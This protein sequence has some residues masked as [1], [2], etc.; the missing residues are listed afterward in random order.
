[1]TQPLDECLPDVIKFLLGEGE[2]D[3][4][5]FGEFPDNGEQYKRRY[6]WR[7]AL[8]E[9]WNLR[10]PNPASEGDVDKITK[11]IFEVMDVMDGIDI[12]AART[13]AEAALAAM[14]PAGNGEVIK[15]A[16][17]WLAEYGNGNDYML[18]TINLIRDLRNAYMEDMK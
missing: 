10:N 3:G 18:G 6:W 12:T 17:K 4:Y 16:D 2:L 13:Y 14:Q 7:K 1:M 11:A 9:A 5:S 8:R 15:K